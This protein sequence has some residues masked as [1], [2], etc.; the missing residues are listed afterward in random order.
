V[1]AGAGQELKDVL[2]QVPT[3]DEL[4]NDG[5]RALIAPDQMQKLLLGMAAQPQGNR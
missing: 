1:G 3:I 5:L 2:S 4:R